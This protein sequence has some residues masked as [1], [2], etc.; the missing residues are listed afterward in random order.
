MWKRPFSALRD[1]IRNVSA[2]DELR[3]IKFLFRKKNYLCDAYIII[4]Y[5][6]SSDRFNMLS[7]A[8][9]ICTAIIGTPITRCT[10]SNE[11]L[12]RAFEVSSMIELNIFD[13]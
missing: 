3:Y 11:V 9:Y 8:C 1:T 4:L 12:K 7:I 5:M 10:T 6:H 2:I 13:T